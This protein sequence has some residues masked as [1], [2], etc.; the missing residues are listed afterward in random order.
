MPEIINIYGIP[1]N[2]NPDKRDIVEG[3]NLEHIASD[4]IS[5]SEANISE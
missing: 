4:N 3:T 2:E 5:A 1:N